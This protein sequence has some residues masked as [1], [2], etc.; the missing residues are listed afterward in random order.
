MM[1]KLNSEDEEESEAEED[2]SEAS[3]KKSVKG[4]SKKYVP[5]RLVPVHYGRSCGCLSLVGVLFLFSFACSR[6]TCVDFITQMRQK[7][8]GNKSVW[9]KPR[10]GL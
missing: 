8:N 1:S 6:I 2:Q 9:R 10:D 5:P 3:G 4:A 7:L